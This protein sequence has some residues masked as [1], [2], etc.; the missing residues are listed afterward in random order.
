MY[1]PNKISRTWD[2]DTASAK[3][4]ADTAD[5]L[6]I[7]HSALADH[8]LRFALVE[9]AAGRLVL[10]VRPVKYELVNVIEDSSPRPGEE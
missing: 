9:V 2:I 8:L 6:K 1:D 4:I 7:S 5:A 3:Q 10:N